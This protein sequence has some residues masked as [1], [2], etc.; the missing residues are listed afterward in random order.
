MHNSLCSFSPFAGNSDRSTSLMVIDAQ[1]KQ[2]REVCSMS[3]SRRLSSEATCP[4]IRSTRHYRTGC[5]TLPC[6]AAGNIVLSHAL[7]RRGV[8][9]STRRR[10]IK[11]RSIFATRSSRHTG[12]ARRLDRAD[13][14]EVGAHAPPAFATLR[15]GEIA[16]QGH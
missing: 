7:H 15:P 12:G 1:Y 6:A 2:S 9:H 10:S 14:L 4:F 13:Y 5:C 11:D 3:F 16:R 8:S